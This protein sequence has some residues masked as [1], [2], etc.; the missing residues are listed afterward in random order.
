MIAYACSEELL[1]PKGKKKKS[2]LLIRLPLSGPEAKLSRVADRGFKT[3]GTKEMQRRQ[4][5]PPFQG[6]SQTL[7]HADTLTHTL[8]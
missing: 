4:R 1:G 5:S 3:E 2:G 6:N 8:L 7:S